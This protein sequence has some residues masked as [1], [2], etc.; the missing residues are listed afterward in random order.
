MA[1]N[2]TTAADLSH[3]FVSA[4]QP[5]FRCVT[6]AKRTSTGGA[7]I[8]RLSGDKMYAMQSEF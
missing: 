6:K 1:E 3:S 7:P 5:G 4:S 2:R 8:K